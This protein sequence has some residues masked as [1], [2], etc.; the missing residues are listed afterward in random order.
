MIGGGDLSNYNSW[1]NQYLNNGIYTPPAGTTWRSTG[2]SQN[3]FNVSTDGRWIQSSDGSVSPNFLASVMGGFGTNPNNPGTVTFPSAPPSPSGGPTPTTTSGGT[4]GGMNEQN[5]LDQLIAAINDPNVQEQFVN[6]PTGQAGLDPFFNTPMYQL[7]YGTNANQVDPAQR[8][9]AD[10]GYDFAQEQAF[11]QMQTYGAAKGLLESGP[12]QVELQKQAQGMADQNYQRWL[13]QQR[14]LYGS[15]QQQ[16]MGLVNA[17]M[18]NNGAGAELQAGMALGPL[19]GGYDMATGGG[20]SAN[21]MSMGQ[22]IATLL[23]NQGSLGASAYLNTAAA[24]ANS[25]MNTYGMGA[26]IANNNAASA[27]GTWNSGQQGIGSLLSAQ[28]VGGG[29]GGPYGSYGDVAPNGAQT[30]TGNPWGSFY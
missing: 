20:I 12:L 23:G 22:I 7:L 1:F 16:L 11:K 24:L 2:S 3:P 28:P 27:A 10:P 5:L 25:N 30:Y 6:A 14:D 17:G 21:N 29:W 9:K 19:L 8:F 13:G 26:Q 15:Y 18:A 4:S